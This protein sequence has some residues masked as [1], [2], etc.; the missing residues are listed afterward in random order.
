[1]KKRIIL[2]LAIADCGAAAKDTERVPAADGAM[3]VRDFY[4]DDSLKTVSRLD[5]DR[6]LLGTL[7]YAPKGIPLHLDYFDAGKHVTKTLIY[8]A[9]GVPN[10]QQH[11]DD[12]G[13]IVFVETFTYEAGKG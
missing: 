3:I 9:D 1:M 8:N 10:R 4:D 11:F 13:A 7:C 12:K 5:R 2:L 6:N